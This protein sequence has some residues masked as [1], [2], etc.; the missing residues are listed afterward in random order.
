MKLLLVIDTL[1]SGGAQRLFV[2]LLNGL[3][4]IYDTE[5]LIYN[6]TGNFI[7]HIRKYKTTIIKKLH[8]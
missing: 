7:I 1:R 3:S 4:D 8:E 2:N 6:S 5:I